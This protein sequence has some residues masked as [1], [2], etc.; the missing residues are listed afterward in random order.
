MNVHNKF[1]PTGIPGLDQLLDG[2]IIRGNSLL[3]E[4]PPGSGKSTLGVR[5]LYEGAV[6]FNEPGLLITFE[7]F[8]RQ[9]YA[10]AL[11]CGIDL[12]QLEDAGKFRIIWTPPSRILQSFR[13]K[14]DLVDQ[15]INEIGV[16]RLLID[17]ITHFRRVSSGE[18]DMR[19]ILSSILTHLKVAGINTMLVKELEKQ[20]DETIAFEEYMVDSSLRL[21]NKR[22][23]MRSENIRYIEIRKTRGQGHISGLHPFHLDDG[24]IQ[25]FPRLRPKDIRKLLPGPV[26]ASRNRVTFGIEGLDTMLHGGLFLGSTSIVSGYAGCGKS[27]LSNHFLSA[28]LKENERGLFLSLKGDAESII[29]AVETTGL[30]WRSD[31]ES[32]RL[33]ILHF[34]PL[35]ACLEEIVYR[36]I[37]EVR[38][39]KPGRFVFDSVDCLAR[40]ARS[41]I[42]FREHLMLITD[43]LRT[44][45][46][47][48]LF[49]LDARSMGGDY[50]DRMLWFTHESSCSI[51]FSMA[52][53]EG[54]L[55]RFIAIMKHA[56]SDHVKELR[57]IRI[58]SNGLHVQSTAAGLSGIL[59]GQAQRALKNLSG[60][61]LPTLGGIDETLYR[62]AANADASNTLVSEISQARQ[63]IGLISAQLREYFGGF[64]LAENIAAPL[65]QYSLTGNILLAED[66]ITNRHVALGILKKLGLHADA[67]TNGAEAV[68]ALKT[69]SYD[70]VLMDVQM[71]VMDGLEATRRIR[72]NQSRVIENKMETGSLHSIPGIDHSSIPIIAMTA[73]A[74]QG[75]R[76]KCLEAGMNDY[77]SKPVTPQALAD[78]LQK[79]LPKRD[80]KIDLINNENHSV[81]PSFSKD[82]AAPVFDRAG[83]MARMMNDED[84]AKEIIASFLEDIPRQIESLWY[85]LNTMDIQGAERQAHSIK[86]ASASIGGE[87]VRALAFEME[88]IALSGNLNSVKDYME[89]LET[90][91]DLLK[92]V[93]HNEIPS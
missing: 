54:A 25:M 73:H 52:E 20:D 46:A 19:E 27:V 92:E 34:E 17:S 90:E 80:E 57:E 41:D 70:L 31:I 83:M 5:I 18:T 26:A 16:R 65:T 36:L 64:D 81:L 77:V 45:G 13:G 40:I 42:H 61:I 48:S 2:G 11:N 72:S 76:E 22:D 8:P 67:V 24:R 60:N 87:R 43:I 91:V 35:A 75:D 47:T 56:G 84:L 50:D 63:Q 53:I 37:L 23:E 38:R 79:W 78:V 86:G 58:D 51:K 49:L 10:E 59:T 7:E 88:K 62:I 66:N 12:Q 28:G 69:K 21:H 44:A 14:I 71:P 9:I 39:I 30:N 32:G 15:I 6:K 93:I 55:R 74:M 82:Q 33:R 4:G 29:S 85:Y 1:M 89:K 3:I 68:M